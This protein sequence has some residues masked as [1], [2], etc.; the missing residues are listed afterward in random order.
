MT[1]KEKTCIPCKEGIDP[2]QKEHYSPLLSQLEHGW[3][4]VDEKYLE[5]TFLFK[6]FEIALEFT[7]RI[8]EIAE[9]EGHHPD[10]FLSWGK[11]VVTLFTHK[12]NGLSESDF[13]LASKLEAPF[14]EC[15]N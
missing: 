11:V 5:K 7:N 4:V 15:Q 8:G 14:Q 12:I 3:N 2:L 10:I 9:N 1:L 13:I 6:N